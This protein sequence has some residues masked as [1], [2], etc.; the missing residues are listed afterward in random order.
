[1]LSIRRVALPLALA[2]V[3]GAVC[4]LLFSQSHQW[5]DR[6]RRG[7]FSATVNVPTGNGH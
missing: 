3:V 1:M 5:G 6:Q 4:V 7:Q 2:G